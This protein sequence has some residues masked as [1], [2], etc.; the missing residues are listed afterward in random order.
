MEY[1]NGGW[2]IA[3]GD[4]VEYFLILGGLLVLPGVQAL[5]GVEGVGGLALHALVADIPVF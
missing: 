3:D 4:I 1:K 5:A 2:S